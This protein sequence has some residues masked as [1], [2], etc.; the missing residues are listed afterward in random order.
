MFSNLNVNIVIN[1]PQVKRKSTNNVELVELW[2]KNV[3]ILPMNRT[4]L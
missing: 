2:A 3:H 1:T 4:S